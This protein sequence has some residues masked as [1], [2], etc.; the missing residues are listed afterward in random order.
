MSGVNMSQISGGAGVA[1][2]AEGAS[3]G[4]V[5]LK[6]KVSLGILILFYMNFNVD[7]QIFPLLANMIADSLTFSDTELGLLQGFIYSIPYGVAVLIAG[8]LVDRFSPR[9]ILFTGTLFW[10]CAASASALAIS[11]MTMAWTRAGVGLGEAMLVPAAL[12]LI[13]AIFPRDKVAL[14]IGLFYA[15]ANLGG[16]VA[17]L[18]GGV[19]IDFFITI[20]HLE[21]PGLGPIAPWRSVFLATGLPGIPLAFLAWSLARAKPATR[22]G[23]TLAAHEPGGAVHGPAVAAPGP[24]VSAG[25]YLRDHWFFLFTYIVGT[26]TLAIAAYTIISWSAPYFGRTYDWSNTTIGIVVAL[27]PGFCIVANPIWGRIS[28]WLLARGH[29]DGVY[30]VLIPAILAGIPLTMLAFLVKQ[31]AVAIVAFVLAN[32][33]LVAYGYCYAALQ[34]AVPPHMRGRLTAIKLMVLALI[35]LGAGPVVAGV[36]TDYVFRSRDMLGPSI[37]SSVTLSVLVSAGLLI[38]GRRAYIRALKAQEQS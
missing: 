38:W 7:K 2:A 36:F 10:A 4:R 31:P 15:G 20:G 1:A 33:C 12:P 23:P 5:S 3:G 37:V 9:G 24:K 30:L 25:Q 16:M 27:G 8:W 29:T 22:G 13:A 21:V 35:G 11:F 19:L 18:A 17:N 34:I 6:A 28:D 26:S 14:A 32:T